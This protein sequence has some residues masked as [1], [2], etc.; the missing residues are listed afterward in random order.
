V[1]YFN[2]FQWQKLY[3]EYRLTKK[4]DCRRGLIESLSLV[5]RGVV[6]RYG[7][8]SAV[9][10]GDDLAQI[11]VI[12]VIEAL[13]DFDPMRGTAFNFFTTVAVRA[14]GRA[15]GTVTD[16]VLDVQTVG[17]KTTRDTIA[18]E[19]N[20]GTRFGNLLSQFIASGEIVSA[21]RF[22]EWLRHRGESTRGVYL[23]L[24]GLRK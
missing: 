20:D 2:E 23:Y 14:I 9:S 8:T 10:D 5:C 3:R 21:K 19:T 17:A 16:S 6:S 11:A 18:I 7:Q 1:N 22:A 12:A 4:E 13:D 24:Q 15:V